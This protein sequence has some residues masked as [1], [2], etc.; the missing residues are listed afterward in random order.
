MNNCS[1]CWV[2][3]ERLSPGC[4]KHLQDCKILTRPELAYSVGG[5]PNSN[6]GRRQNGDYIRVLLFSILSYHCYRVGVH[7]AYSAISCMGGPRCK[8]WEG[9]CW[10]V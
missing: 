6:S 4:S 2:V 5:P 1:V 7:L 8:V 3:S 10:K 9:F